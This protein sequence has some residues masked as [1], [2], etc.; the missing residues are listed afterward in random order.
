MSAGQSSNTT[1]GR[2]RRVTTEGPLG[3]PATCDGAD[4]HPCNKHD[5]ITCLVH[6][7]KCKT[8]WGESDEELR[9]EAQVAYLVSRRRD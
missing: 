4:P 8:C 2:S 9:A 6:I 1:S 7:Y 3:V 5:C